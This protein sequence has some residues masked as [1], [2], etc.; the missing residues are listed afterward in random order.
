VP[1][2]GP[3]R[4]RLRGREAAEGLLAEAPLQAVHGHTQ[5][6]GNFFVGHLDG[7]GGH[8]PSIVS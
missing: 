2:H 3:E 8:A 4:R 7:L 1:A 6:T 5:S